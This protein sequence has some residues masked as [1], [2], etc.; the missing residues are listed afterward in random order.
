MI[1]SYDEVTAGWLSEA[2]DLDVSDVAWASD[3]AGG[4]ALTSTVKRCRVTLADGEERGLV[5]KLRN[6][7]WEDPSFY[8][9]EVRFY[10][11]FAPQLGREV[12]ACSYAAYDSGDY[13][14]VLEDLTDATP[15]HPID[16]LDVGSAMIAGSALGRIHG[17]FWGAEVDDFWHRPYLQPDAIERIVARHD[18]RWPQLS[19]D[20]RFAVSAELAEAVAA[21]RPQ[22]ADDLASL[23][24]DART[25]VHLDLHAEN[26]IVDGRRTVFLDWQ[27]A[28]LG[29]PAFDLAGLV[30]C[31]SADKA[32]FW[33]P[34]V[35]SWKGGVV[36]KLGVVVGDASGQIGRVADQLK[37]AVRYIFI[38]HAN[39][40]AT[41]EV[42]ALRQQDVLAAHWK[43]L[44][45]A[46]LESRIRHA[47]G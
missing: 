18:E 47:G 15:G 44:C 46:Y 2:L 1:R 4:I 7:E 35:R 41:P 31:L 19:A 30:T 32:D 37:A 8:E 5:V 25:L 17:L 33:K 21:L 34:V 45:A 26:I 13:A 6:P 40:L 12:P 39:W 28:R 14:L 42:A 29:N 36:A 27:N 16:G 10:Q 23:A 9:R 20:G 3:T 38:G 22:L 24:G 11:E 43:R